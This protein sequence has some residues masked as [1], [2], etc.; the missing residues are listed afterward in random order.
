MTTI[1]T[2][3]KKLSILRYIGQLLDKSMCRQIEKNH[4]ANRFFLEE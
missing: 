4:T 1:I 2:I 3:S